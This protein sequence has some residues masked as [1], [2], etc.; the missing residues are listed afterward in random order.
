MTGQRQYLDKQYRKINVILQIKKNIT[1]N[2]KYTFSAIFVA[3][4]MVLLVGCEEDP[5]PGNV[6]I[7]FNYE[8]GNKSL[9]L[10]QMIYQAPLGY[11]YMVSNHI[12]YISRINLVDAGGNTEELAFTHLRDIHDAST[13]SLKISN[14]KTGTY[15]AISFV[16]GLNET[17]NDQS[18]LDNTVENQG[19]YWPAPLTGDN[20]PPAFHYMKYEGKYKELDSDELVNFNLHLG[21][22]MGNDNSFAVNLPFDSEMTIDNNSLLI[23]L[24][25]DLQEWLQNP[26]SY[27][28]KTYG[29]IIMPKQDAQE[30]LKVNGSTVFNLGAVKFE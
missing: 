20:L 29:Q 9:E 7:N 26:N 21:P 25:L 28:Y 27:D 6:N 4:L 1:M 10:D 15:K 24:D 2:K 8:I 5:L 22:T 14:V 3:F 23:N 19:M 16:F 30:E 11:E 17:D 18:K 12:Y 13:S